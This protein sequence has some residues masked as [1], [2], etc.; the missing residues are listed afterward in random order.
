MTTRRASSVVREGKRIHSAYGATPPNHRG[1]R[2]SEPSISS[3][4]ESYTPNR[5]VSVLYHVVAAPTSTLPAVVPGRCDPMPG[6][7]ILCPS[8]APLGMVKS[9]RARSSMVR[10]PL[11]LDESAQRARKV[12][13]DRPGL[14]W[15]PTC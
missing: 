11:H 12:T 5:R 1:G 8:G 6:K 9:S 3:N 14:R 10:S 15:I 13:T 4:N 2:R 7:L